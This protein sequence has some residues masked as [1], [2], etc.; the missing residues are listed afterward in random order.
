M[1][2]KNVET[3]EAL[4]EREREREHSL[5]WRLFGVNEKYTR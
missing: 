3:L 1:G 4:R 5:E 2:N